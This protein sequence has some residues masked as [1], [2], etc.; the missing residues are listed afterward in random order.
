M[1]VCGTCMISQIDLAGLPLGVLGQLAGDERLSPTLD[2]ILELLGQAPLP[3]AAAAAEA[4]VQQVAAASGDVVPTQSLSG[5]HRP[6]GVPPPGGDSTGSTMAD[7][8]PGQAGA[9]AMEADAG[10]GAAEQEGGDL[11]GVAAEYA[12]AGAV[13]LADADFCAGAPCSVSL[14]ACAAVGEQ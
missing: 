11:E 13:P 3:R 4:F 8:L 1:P 2:A 9:E 5:L 6:A 7:G 10:S 12:C 14:A